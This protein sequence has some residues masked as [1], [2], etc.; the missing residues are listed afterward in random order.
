MHGR[1]W[2]K[3]MVTGRKAGCERNTEGKQNVGEG[4]RGKRTRKKKRDAKERRSNDGSK[5][6]NDEEGNREERRG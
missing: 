3:K 6:R 5:E 2:K 1:G 4:A